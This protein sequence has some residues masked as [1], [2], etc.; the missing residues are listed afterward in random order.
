MLLLLVLLRHLYYIFLFQCALMT[1][2]KLF[3]S[4]LNGI[5]N[6]VSSSI[7]RNKKSQ[8]VSRYFLLICTRNGRYRTLIWLSALGFSCLFVCLIF[9]FMWFGRK[10]LGRI[11]PRSLGYLRF[12]GS[13]CGDAPGMQAPGGSSLTALLCGTNGKPQSRTPT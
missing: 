6:S 7:L 10:P 13:M 2:V 5:R 11:P 8:V 9:A 12:E 4:F 1:S 3:M